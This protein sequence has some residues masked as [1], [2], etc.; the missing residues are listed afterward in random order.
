MVLDRVQ[1]SAL[2]WC[3]D[4]DCECDCGRTSS[5]R[6]LDRPPLADMDNFRGCSDVLLDA[7][8]VSSSS[9]TAAPQYVVRR[10][11]QLARDTA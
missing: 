3:R 5:H 1:P 6:V 8:Q 7:A 4:C 10:E 2:R 9:F 11:C